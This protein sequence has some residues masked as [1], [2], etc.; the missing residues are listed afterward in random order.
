MCSRPASTSSQGRR[1]CRPAHSKAMKSC[2]TQHA[3][4]DGRLVQD[5]PHQLRPLHYIQPHNTPENLAQARCQRPRRRQRKAK[6]ISHPFQPAIPLLKVAVLL[7]N[8][9]S[10]LTLPHY[11]TQIHR[12]RI[13]LRRAL[14]CFNVC[15]RRINNE[16]PDLMRAHSAHQTSTQ[17]TVT[18]RT[19]SELAARCG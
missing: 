15:N 3:P 17:V 2:A 11:K 19:A 16:M 1:R 7:P 9:F 12:Q 5:D 4:I 13:S 14:L 10:D 18:R 6:R 8:L